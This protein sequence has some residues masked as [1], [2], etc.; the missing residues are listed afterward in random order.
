MLRKSPTSALRFNIEER[1]ENMTVPAF[2]TS[3][4]GMPKIG[5]DGSYLA[6][7]A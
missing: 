7:T 1:L 5:E 4:T 3:S 6:A 2:Q